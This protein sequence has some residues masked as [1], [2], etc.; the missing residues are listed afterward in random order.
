MH[1][2]WSLPL[3]SYVQDFETDR[4]IQASLKCLPPPVELIRNHAR[5]ARLARIEK[6]NVTNSSHNVRNAVLYP[7]GSS[8]V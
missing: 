3:R 7:E 5:A 8:L 1:L 2:Y 4:G 6:S